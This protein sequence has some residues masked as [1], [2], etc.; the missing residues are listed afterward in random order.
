[1][2]SGI[3]IEGIGIDIAFFFQG[4][5]IRFQMVDIPFLRIFDKRRSQRRNS[6]DFAAIKI[7][8]IVRS[9]IFNQFSGIFINKHGITTFHGKG[10]HKGEENE[11]GARRGKNGSDLC[12]RKG[13]TCDSHISRRQE[14]GGSELCETAGGTS[15]IQADPGCSGKAAGKVMQWI[16]IDMPSARIA[17]RNGT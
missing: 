4:G 13:N 15:S 12:R 2:Y 9:E 6:V 5:K 11:S 3:A 14:G 8:R 17:G 7:G 10:Y 1:M 16:H